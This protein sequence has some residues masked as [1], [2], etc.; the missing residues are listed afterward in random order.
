M[1]GRKEEGGFKREED[2]REERGWNQRGERKDV[3]RGDEGKQD[4]QY[5]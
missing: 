5:R 2:I 4:V 1:T 3:E